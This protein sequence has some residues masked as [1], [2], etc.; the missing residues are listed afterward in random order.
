MLDAPTQLQQSRD[1]NKNANASGAAKPKIHLRHG[2]ARSRRDTD[3]HLER[4]ARLDIGAYCRREIA[5]R[6]ERAPGSGERFGDQAIQQRGCHARIRCPANEIEAF[7]QRHPTVEGAQVV[8]VPMPAGVKPV[9]FVTLK[10]GT[11]LDEAALKEHCE[12]GLARYKV[13][14]RIV[15][16]DVFPTTL[17][18]NGL[19]IQKAKLREDARMLLVGAA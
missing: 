13:P 8:G 2:G 1:P 6:C 12:A 5:V 19:K 10:S 7:L 17:S 14:V 18:P 15:A 11:N 9:A 3:V 4:S 16:V